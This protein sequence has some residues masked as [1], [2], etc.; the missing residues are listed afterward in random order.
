MTTAL[1]LFVALL[2]AFGA[3]IALPLLLLKLLL[4]VVLGVALL[5]FKILGGLAKAAGA[6][7]ALFG[8]LIGVAFGAVGIALGF[9]VFVVALPLFPLLLLGAFIWLMAKALQPRP[10][11][12]L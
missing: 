11:R 9:V 3:L 6:V 10:A 8:K 5:P 12:P 1:F 4:H 2:I 7:L